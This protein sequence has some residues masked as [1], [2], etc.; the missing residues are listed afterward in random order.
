[1][2]EVMQ[3][4]L[5]LS[6]DEYSKIFFLTKVMERWVS[7]ALNFIANF[8]GNG[9]CGELK[10]IVSSRLF[11]PSRRLLLTATQ[12][13]FLTIAAVGLRDSVD[14]ALVG[15][16]VVYSLQMLGRRWAIALQNSFI[17]IPRPNLM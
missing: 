13:F 6:L 14:P 3:D 5:H 10:S 17:Y 12:G 7:L 16:A 1:M 11:A 4:K 8:Y 2:T 9:G 15:L